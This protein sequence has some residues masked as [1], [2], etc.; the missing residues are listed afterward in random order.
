MIIL[1]AAF[2]IGL[3]IPAGTFWGREM[4]NTTVRNRKDVEDAVSIPLL[5]DIPLRARKKGKN[6]E[7]EHKIVVRESGRDSVSEAFRIIRTNMDFMQVKADNLQVIQF[8][9]FHPGSGKTFVSMNL[10][11]SIA[12]TKKKVILVDLDIR[13]H[14]LSSFVQK[15]ENTLGISNYLSGRVT[16]YH[17]LINKKLLEE[18]DQLDIICAGPVPPNPAELLLSER[19]DYL[20]E[21]LRKEY[22][23]IFL[24]NV[25]A[26]MVADATIVNRVVD[27]TLYIVR[28]GLMDRRQLP[29]L[30]R[31]Y[32]QGKFKNMAVVLN[33]VNYQHTGYGYYGYGYQYG[34]SYGYGYHNQKEKKF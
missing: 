5:G 27:L 18:S 33:A 10:A 28:A 29:E 3:V 13:K 6:K 1:L 15:G 2:I 17:T 8:T 14:T 23:Y 32:Q 34:Y 21:E 16:D 12:M 26:G 22:D 11:M 25:P 7:K 20:I 4:L 19:L 9:S 30:E 24:D 31:L